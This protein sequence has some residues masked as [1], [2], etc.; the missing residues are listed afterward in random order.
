MAANGSFTYTPDSD[1]SGS[2]SFTYTVTDADGSTSTATVNVTVTA[3]ADTPTVTLD[4]SGVDSVNPPASTGLVF[5]TYEDLDNNVVMLLPKKPAQATATPD[6]VIRQ[7]NGFGNAT[8]VE[9]FLLSKPMA[10]PS[11]FLR[12]D[13][14]AITGLIYLEAGSTYDF[15]G[16]RDDSLRIELGG[17]TIISTTG[18]SYGNYGLDHIGQFGGIVEPLLLLLLLVTTHLRHM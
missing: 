11:Q 15:S 18:D 1:F 12:E 10:L 7:V 17:E 14:V 4:A 6:S 3:V 9:S 2:D 16:Y 5:S 13:S 8:D